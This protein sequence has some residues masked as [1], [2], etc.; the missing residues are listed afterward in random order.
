MQTMLSPLPFQSDGVA[1]IL[2]PLP[3]NRWP[4]RQLATSTRGNRAPSAFRTACQCTRAR[5]PPCWVTA[6]DAVT[7]DG[8]PTPALSRR[9]EKMRSCLLLLLARVHQSSV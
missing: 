3:R 1:D 4:A 2:A 9:D 8:T 5:V 7:A 6:G